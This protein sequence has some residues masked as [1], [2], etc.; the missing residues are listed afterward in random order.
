MSEHL[1]A[2]VDTLL[3]GVVRYGVLCKLWSFWLVCYWP[4]HRPTEATLRSAG[5][6]GSIL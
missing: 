3:C 5:V 2:L 1:C 6:R 4:P